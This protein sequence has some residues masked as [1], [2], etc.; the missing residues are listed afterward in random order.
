MQKKVAGE[1]LYRA[2]EIAEEQQPE[3]QTQPG[4]AAVA[5]PVQVAVRGAFGHEEHDAGAS[6]QR[7][8]GKKV[9]GSQEQV[10]RKGDEQAD[11]G[12]AG[13]VVGVRMQPAGG[14][15]DS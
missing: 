14:E 12:E 7:R 11:H 2:V 6:V 4:V 15:A 10:E 3:E 9:E 8:K 1:G 13:P 5:Q